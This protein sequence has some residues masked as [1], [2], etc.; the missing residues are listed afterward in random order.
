MTYR[1]LAVV[2][3]V[4]GIMACLGTAGPRA[5][6]SYIRHHLETMGVLAGLAVM[7]CG[8]LSIKLAS[9]ESSLE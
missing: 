9:L 6:S 1:T 4:C 7:F 5:V 3:L 2:S 8:F